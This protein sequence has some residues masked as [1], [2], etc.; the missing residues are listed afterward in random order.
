[1]LFFSRTLAPSTP[2][3]ALLSWSVF[4]RFGFLRLGTQEI[5]FLRRNLFLS[6]SKL[7]TFPAVLTLQFSGGSGE[8]LL[9]RLNSEMMRLFSQPRVSFSFTVASKA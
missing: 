7:K 9:T 3:L 2:L 5:I 6:F 1:M 8:E 4:S